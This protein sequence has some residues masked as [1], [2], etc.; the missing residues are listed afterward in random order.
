MTE[1]RWAT[2][3]WVADGCADRPDVA[4][5]KS[6]SANLNARGL[7]RIRRNPWH[8]EIT[9]AGQRLLDQGPTVPENVPP[10]VSPREARPR[11]PSRGRGRGR[12]ADHH[13]PVVPHQTPV[14]AGVPPCHHHSRRHA[15]RPAD[16]VHG[17]QQ[18]R[19]RVLGG[20]LRPRGG[21]EGQ[22]HEGRQAGTLGLDRAASP[23]R[24]QEDQG[25]PV[26]ATGR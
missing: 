10:P 19:P 21:G 11:S 4:S 6:T 3:R 17:P 2:L 14:P 20:A 18:R 12:E 26:T 9:A 25:S 24:L 23:S 16:A 5:L 13:Q 7:I 8:A 1:N 15:R 22:G